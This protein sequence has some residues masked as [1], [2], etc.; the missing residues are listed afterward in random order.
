MT[1]SVR[2]IDGTRTS[3]VNRD[4]HIY[5]SR[6]VRRVNYPIASDRILFIFGFFFSPPPPSVYSPIS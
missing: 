3:R 5:Y 6:R 4:T 1:G 2:K